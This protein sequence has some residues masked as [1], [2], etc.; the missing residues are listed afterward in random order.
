MTR[1]RQRMRI[2]G[3]QR[4]RT[5]T[6]SSGVVRELRIAYAQVRRRR[7]VRSLQRRAILRRHFM[8]K[9]HYFA[10]LLIRGFVVRQKNAQCCIRMEWRLSVCL[11]V[12]PSQ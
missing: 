2:G 12:C 6:S 8:L 10:S 3:R 5:G 11:S 7:R 9:L 4:R 1:D